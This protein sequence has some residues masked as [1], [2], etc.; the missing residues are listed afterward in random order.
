[1]TTGALIFAYNN[2]QLDYLAMARWSARNINRHLGIPTAIITN[3]PFV[4]Q[5]YET[6]ILADP[7]STN[8]R[9][10]KDVGTVT[11]HNTNRM[12]AYGLTPWDRTLLLDADYVV[13]SDRLK[14]L[15]EVDQDFLT[16]KTAY[17]VTGLVNFDEV[18][19]FGIHRMPMWWATVIMFRRSQQAE[20][21][22]DTMQMIRNNWQ[23]YINLHGVSRVV[24]RNDYALSM[25]LGIVN[26]HIL[27]HPGIP[28]ELASV[29]PDH[30]LTQLGP[31]EYRVDFITPDQKAKWIK[32]TGDFH[33]MGKK[34]LGDI[35]ANPA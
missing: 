32:L 4:A 10:F 28:G 33:A 11:W 35:I 34:Q 19:N 5:A 23:H 22:F 14:T 25:A 17:D 18:N 27:D 26:G 16:Y 21:I 30:R 8:Q 1:M 13:A 15:L 20:M 31:D 3:E 2:E 9:H 24:Y 12:D 6:C 29:N 7:S